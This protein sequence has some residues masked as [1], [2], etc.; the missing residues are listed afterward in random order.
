MYKRGEWDLGN[1]FE[2]QIKLLLRVVE[3]MLKSAAVEQDD[4]KRLEK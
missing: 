3:I 4:F 1:N 2:A